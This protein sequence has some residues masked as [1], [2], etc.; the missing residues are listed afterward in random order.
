MENN[1]RDFLK[2]LILEEHSRPQAHRILDWIGSDAGR[3]ALL[4]SI[5]LEGEYRTTQRAAWPL[6]DLGTKHPELL[7]PHLPKM[8]AFLKK[9]GNHVAVTR[10]M[11]RILGQIELPKEH[12]GEI[13]DLVF[14]SAADPKEPIAI[15][16][17]S[18]TVAWRV[19]QIEPELSGELRMIIE[20]HLPFA[21]AAFKVRS[22]NILAAMRS[23]PK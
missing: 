15:R 9:T 5:F 18:L 1:D 13:A 14:K 21:T 6:G 20:A 23:F 19:C 11:L 16:A 8:L 10:N 17:F 7:E 2:N 12:L 3:A 4:V 22:R